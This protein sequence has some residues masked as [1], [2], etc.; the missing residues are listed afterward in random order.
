M[1][2]FKVRNTAH[3]F[4]RAGENS[5]TEVHPDF[6]SDDYLACIANEISDDTSNLS[7]TSFSKISQVVLWQISW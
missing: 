4:I 5:S 7:Y 2:F 3:E 6:D 1:T